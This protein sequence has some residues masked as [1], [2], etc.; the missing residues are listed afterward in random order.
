M[1]SSAYQVV[2][3][4]FCVYWDVEMRTIP[5]DEE[6]GSINVETVTD[7]L[8]EYTIG[9]V[10]ILGITYTGRYDD[11]KALDK[12]LEAYNKH[13]DYKSIYPRGCCKWWVVCPIYGARA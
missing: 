9:V 4:K 2:W 3:E 7:Y 13:T 8:D 6:H 1:I 5:I 11:I 12:K 10:G